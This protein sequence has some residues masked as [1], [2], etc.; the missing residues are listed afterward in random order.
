M[1]P[2]IS[3]VSTGAGAVFAAFWAASVLVS[4]RNP[5]PADLADAVLAGVCAL[6]EE[7][8]TR[9]KGQTEKRMETIL[10]S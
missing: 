2:R 6:T 3:G 9:T 8:A 7:S 10:A 4:L 5:Y 1:S